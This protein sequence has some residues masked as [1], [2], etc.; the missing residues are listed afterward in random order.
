MSGRRGRGSV[1]LGAVCRVRCGRRSAIAADQ[2]AGRV[3]EE[4]DIA[5]ALAVDV[6]GRRITGEPVERPRTGDQ[7]LAAVGAFDYGEDLGVE[8][9]R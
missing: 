8:T 7:L 2:P 1:P 5:R 3:D 6:T 9:L 4:P